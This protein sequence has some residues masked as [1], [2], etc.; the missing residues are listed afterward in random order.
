[1]NGDITNKL[2]DNIFKT[3]FGELITH[4]SIRALQYDQA[5]Y[6]T[7]KFLARDAKSESSAIR[8]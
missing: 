8:S 7:T 6:P 2:L 5:V 1:M 3:L 4:E